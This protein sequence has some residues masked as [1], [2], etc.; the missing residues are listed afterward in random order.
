VQQNQLEFAITSALT[1]M[2]T[3]DAVV[4]VNCDRAVPVEHLVNVMRICN[5]LKA[6]V[7]LATQPE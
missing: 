2:T 5:N 6:K 3:T 4:S 7:V 1:T